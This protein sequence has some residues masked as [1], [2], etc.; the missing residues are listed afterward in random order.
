MKLPLTIEASEGE[1]SVV[2]K[3]KAPQRYRLQLEVRKT[4]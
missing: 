2:I 3:K 1:I 4:V